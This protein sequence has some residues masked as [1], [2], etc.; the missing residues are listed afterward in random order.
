M[1]YCTEVYNILGYL[2][3]NKKK[4]LDNWHNLDVVFLFFFNALQR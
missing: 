2:Y 1:N 4:N 3:S